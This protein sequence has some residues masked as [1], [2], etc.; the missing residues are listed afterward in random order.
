MWSL[1][2]SPVVTFLDIKDHYDLKNDF[3]CTFKLDAKY[4]QKSY[5]IVAIFK[6]GWNNTS[7]YITGK[8]VRD[9]NTE[10]IGQITF[11]G[12]LLPRDT[13]NLYQ[14]CYIS[15]QE[16]KGAS[17]PFDFSVEYQPLTT[18]EILSSQVLISCDSTAMCQVILEKDIE[19]TKLKE[20]IASL[21]EENNILKKSLKVFLD[22]K[23]E[24]SFK[25]YDQDI[26]KLKGSVEGIEHIV[27]RHNK[28]IKMLKNK[29]VE[30]EEEYKKLYFEKLKIEKK[31]EKLKDTYCSDKGWVHE[32]EEFIDVNKDLGELQPLPPFPFMLQHSHSD[33]KA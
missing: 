2:N 13:S 10:Q 5:D 1:M 4:V 8:A 12:Y 21:T 6:L 29:V 14:V 20:M 26:T 17:S 27:L 25:N 22:E 30:G 9:V 15:N 18:S 11:L 24:S 28:D 19:I 32:E 33:S 7:E 3:T 31:Y 23:M 16:L